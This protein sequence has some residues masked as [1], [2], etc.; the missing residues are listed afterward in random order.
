MVDA[1]TGVPVP[2]ATI[3]VLHSTKGVIATE[4]GEFELLADRSDSIIITSVGYEQLL[5]TGD[6][7]GMVTSLQPKIKT[8]GEVT[9]RDKK[10][11]RTVI[12]GNGAGVLNEDIS[13]RKKEGDCWNWGPSDIKEEFAEKILLP[14]RTLTYQLR[15]IIVPVCKGSCWG[16]LL[17][18]VYA[19]NGTSLFPGEEVF[20]KAI[21]PGTLP[22]KANKLEIDL[23]MEK[24]YFENNDHLFISF[25]WLPGAT[26]QK[27]IT[28]MVF[29]S[30]KAEI[31]TYSRS[32][33]SASYQW[34]P[35]GLVEGKG[36]DL[37]I[38]PSSMY[39]VELWEMK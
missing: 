16:N 21:D 25:G 8:L 17:L 7:F 23:S 32:L 38:R 27:C 34:K 9:M 11:L 15:K 13:C 24:L 2:F 35:M 18:H 33:A 29:P 3:K 37:H 20:V 28:A 1:V 4:E 22:V 12:L 31:N 26:K 39:A 14:S 10:Y 5:I 6:N 30:A 19:E 36:D